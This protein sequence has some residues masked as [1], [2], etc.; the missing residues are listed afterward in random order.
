VSRYACV[1]AQAAAGFP[2]TM[3]CE[4][5]G[6][7][8]SGFYDHKTRQSNGPTKREVAEA[9]IVELMREI[10]AASDGN[11]GVPRMWRAL[12]RGGITINIKR[13][14]R[15]MRVHGM[16][17]RF[18]Q[19]RVRTTFPGPDGY[20]IA[21]LI[22]R[23]FAPGAPDVAWCQDITYIPTGEGWL[24]LASVLDLGSRRLLGYS[25]A[26]HMR[27]ELVTDALSMAIAARG[28]RVDGVI[29]H[30]DRGSQY[31]SND[32]LD[33]CLAHQI[34]PSVG[35]TGVCWDNAVAESFWESLKREC[36]Q[37]RVFATR[38]D[39]RRAIFRWLNWYNTS[40]LH[41]SLDHM[42]PCE[43]EQQYRQAS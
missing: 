41:S 36:I 42:P 34:R 19:R 2:V 10:Y 21:D 16:A 26:E 30:A 4:A 38:A 33:F 17:G 31:T 35:R 32:Y 28:G 23:N 11:Y 3:A 40:R 39:A 5:A 14:Q 15:L 9:E 12:R 13:V 18:R 22:A 8:T 24:F 27:T 1:D 20:V 6:V 43:W 7:S 25:M 29:G 37:D